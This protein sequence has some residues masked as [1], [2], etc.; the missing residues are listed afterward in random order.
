MST[1]T[2]TERRLEL[3]NKLI[4]VLGSNNVY[5]QPPETMKMSYPCIIYNKNAYPGRYADDI[6]YK[7]KQNYSVTVVDHDPDSEIAYDI[8]K[9][10]QYCRID[11]YYRSNGLNHTKLTLYY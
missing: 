7:A 2:E 6:V 11:S 5:F 9:T 3:H 1:K 4:N 10:F 8:Q